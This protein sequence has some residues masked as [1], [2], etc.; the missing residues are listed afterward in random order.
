MRTDIITIEAVGNL[1]LYYRSDLEYI[2]SFQKCKRHGGDYQTYFKP[3]VLSKFLAEYRVARNVKKGQTER[4]LETVIAYIKTDQVDNVD[5]LA[6]KLR[7]RR[8]TQED[9]NMVS[10]ASKILFLNKPWKIL[11]YDRF[12]RIGIECSGNTYSSYLE[13]VQKSKKRILKLYNALP[14]SILAYLQLIEADFASDITHLD[15]IRKNRFV[16]KTLWSLGRAEKGLTYL[17]R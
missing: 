14:K 3:T 7:D 2:R 4:L 12:V 16:D 17:D 6:K 8:I 15:K 5:Y 13:A 11:P 1:L 9:K 10:L